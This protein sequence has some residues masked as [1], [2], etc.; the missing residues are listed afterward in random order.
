M[1]SFYWYYLGL[2]ERERIGMI[3]PWDGP[4]QAGEMETGRARMQVTTTLL[5][6]NY[7]NA[8]LCHLHAS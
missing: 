2:R 8:S 1:L 4:E 6:I 7:I 3:P 5:I